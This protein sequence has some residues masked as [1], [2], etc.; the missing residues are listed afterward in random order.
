M[1]LTPTLAHPPLKI[2]ALALKAAD[3]AAIRALRAAPL[4]KLLDT[5]LDKMS[6]E[7]FE[8]TSNTMLFNQTGQP[9]MSVP[10]YR[11]PA[12]LPIGT[13]LVARYGEEA[14]LLR[15]AAQ[16]EQ[17]RPWFDRRPPRRE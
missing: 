11:S 5:A 14:L 3:A 10:L 16:L 2:G 15:V 1:F 13:Q 9:A 17:A 8:A 7:A 12:G 4:A 6:G